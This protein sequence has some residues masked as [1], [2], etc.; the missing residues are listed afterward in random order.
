MVRSLC[1]ALR[2][3][4]VFLF[5]LVAL[6]GSSPAL[7]DTVSA[8]SVRSA[9]VA[10]DLGFTS[11]RHAH[12]PRVLADASAGPIVDPTLMVNT[13]RGGRRTTRRY[14]E[15]KSELADVTPQG[16]ESSNV[17]T[18]LVFGSLAVMATLGIGLTCFSVVRSR[19]RGRAG[20]AAA[21]ALL[22]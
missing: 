20:S 22:R 1:F 2:V 10:A 19:A 16:D 11:V 18:G 13:D 9:G 4:F 12:P 21:A 8:A 15:S 3:E 17:P 7:A 14:R 6:L 5:S